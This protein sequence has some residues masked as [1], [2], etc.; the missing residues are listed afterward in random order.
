MQMNSF[1]NL[2]IPLQSINSFTRFSHTL[3]FC[4]LRL[5]WIYNRIYIINNRQTKSTRVR[6][7]SGHKQDNNGKPELNE[8][9][10]LG[11]TKTQ[12]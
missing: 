7:K 8:N 1:T 5:C 11:N 9:N 3:I 12:K 2:E 6:E 4:I 10:R